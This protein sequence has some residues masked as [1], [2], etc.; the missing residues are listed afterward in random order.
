MK[1]TKIFSDN[2]EAGAIAQFNEAMSL[3]CNV[4]GALM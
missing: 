2:I 4:A 1:Q 3:P